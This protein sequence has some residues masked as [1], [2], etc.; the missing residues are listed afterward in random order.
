[1]LSEM[2]ADLPVGH[3][4]C[5]IASYCYQERLFDKEVRE[6]NTAALLA[7]RKRFRARFDKIALRYPPRIAVNL[8]DL[9]DM[10]SAITDGGIILSK[11]VKDKGALARQIM[12]YRDFVRAVFLG[13]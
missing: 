3:P 7:W 6:L 10:V 1:M 12:L 9:A 8:D 5:L 11:V 2:L 4:G 13:A